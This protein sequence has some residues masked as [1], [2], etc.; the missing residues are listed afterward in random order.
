MWILL[1]EPGREGT[2][3]A[4]AD[5]DDLSISLINVHSGDKVGNI[6]QSLLSSEILEIRQLQISIWDGFTIESVLQS[7]KL[8]LVLRSN[9]K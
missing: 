2:W 5:D 1:S 7:N 3:I 8:S 4:S 6:G 9:H